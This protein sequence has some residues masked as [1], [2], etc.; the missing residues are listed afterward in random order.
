MANDTAN[1]VKVYGMPPETGRWVFVLAGMIMNLCLGTVY[2]WSVFRKPLQELFS[3]PE[4]KITATQTLLPFVLFLAFFTVLMP[5]SG[6][7]LQR[8]I[9]PRVLSIIGSVLVAA[10]WIL[11]R[12]ASDINYLYLTYGVVAG[13]G[14]GIVYGIPIAVVTKW[15]PDIKGLTVGLTVLGFGV[16]ALVMAPLAQALI[17]T[18]GILNTFLILGIAFLVALVLMSLVLRFPPAGWQPEG[19]QGAAAAASVRNYT[20]AEMLTTSSCLGLWLCFIIGSLGGLLAI[21]ISSNVG[22]EIVKLRPAT[23]AGLVSFFALFN[24]GGRPLF[25]WLTDAIGHSKAAALSLFMVALAS[26]GMLLAGEGSVVLYAACFAAFWM[27]LGSWLAIAPTATAAY[28]GAK[29]YATNYGIIFSAYGIGA[30]A[31]SLSAGIVRDF[32]GSYIRV[33]HVSGSLATVGVLI[34]LTLMKPPKT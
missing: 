31:A 26:G 11:S 18:K 13:M 34:A 30:I 29:N 25:G 32:F 4:V 1:D 15:F 24:G 23:A 21:S 14:V 17:E 6:R 8:G 3:T 2:A 19:W 27:G 7:L 12:Y 5:I 16:S 10:G 20:P 9:H 22:Q 28:F 33:F